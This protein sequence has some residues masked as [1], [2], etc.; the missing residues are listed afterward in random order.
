MGPSRPVSEPNLSSVG[1]TQQSPLQKQDDETPTAWKG[2]RKSS[3]RGKERVSESSQGTPSSTKSKN[4]GLKKRWSADEIQKNNN[5]RFSKGPS[6]QSS[7]DSSIDRSIESLG[8]ASRKSNLKSHSQ[9]NGETS[10]KARVPEI[11]LEK[12]EDNELTFTRREGSP[13]IQSVAQG[14]PK[15]EGATPSL[16]SS[17]KNVPTERSLPQEGATLKFI[18]ESDSEPEFMDTYL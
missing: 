5:V 14:S 1:T 10:A 3:K 9:S 15:T 11:G 6:R 16:T 2:R 12:D 8:K 4:K 13:S 17:V 18:D 7:M